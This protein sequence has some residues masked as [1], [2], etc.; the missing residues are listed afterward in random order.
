MN[1][2]GLK[3]SLENYDKEQEEKRIAEEKQKKEQ[4]IRKQKNIDSLLNKC[5]L[6]DIKQYNTELI[7]AIKNI[8]DEDLQSLMEQIII[9]NRDNEYIV[10]TCKLTNLD[11][12]MSDWRCSD[13]IQGDYA[14]SGKFEFR[15]VRDIILH[16]NGI[17]LIEIKKDPINFDFNIDN[18]DDDY[19]R[20]EQQM[21]EY[22]TFFEYVE[23]M[24]HF[25]RDY[26]FD[27]G[28][29]HNTH[30]NYSSR[31]S[32]INHT[33]F[34]NVNE[35]AEILVQRLTDFGL[36]VVDTTIEETTEDSKAETIYIKVKNPLK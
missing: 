35:I 26:E 18:A 10:L 5:G 20:E 25:S 21:K 17:S 22:T 11:L 3:N 1:I 27:D 31:C 6:Q 28:G 7:T 34:F 4:A 24:Y 2:D 16:I 12:Y 32:T 29:G 9:K 33:K 23:S 8:S 13:I 19:K 15:F 14:Y 30:R 36:V